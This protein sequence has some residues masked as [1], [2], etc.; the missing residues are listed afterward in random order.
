MKMMMRWEMISDVWKAKGW[1]NEDKEKWG[2]LKTKS[3]PKFCFWNI[4]IV[5]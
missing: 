5:S 1:L 4:G 2:Y 3:A